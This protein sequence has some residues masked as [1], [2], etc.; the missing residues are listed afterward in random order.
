[1]DI[2]CI[3]TQEGWLYLAGVLDACSRKIVGW[4][5]ADTMST[6]LVAR[7]FERAAHSE[8]PAPGLLHRSDRGSQDR[9]RC[10]PRVAASKRHRSEQEPG[11]QLL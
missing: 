7:A 3:A 8:R 6:S 1:M 2:T 5:L 4:A 10:L 9:Q 11:G